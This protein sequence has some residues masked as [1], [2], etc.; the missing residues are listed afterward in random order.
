MS[1]GLLPF[2]VGLSKGWAWSQNG[3]DSKNQDP[4]PLG[5]GSHVMCLQLCFCLKESQSSIQ[6]QERKLY[7]WERDKVRMGDLVHS[8]SLYLGAIQYLPSQQAVL[9]INLTSFLEVSLIFFT[10]ID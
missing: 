7:S 2:H 3:A 5:F 4:W 1:Y 6:S 10:L 9:Q 8:S